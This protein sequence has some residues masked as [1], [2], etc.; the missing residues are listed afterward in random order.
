M[1][2]GEEAPEREGDQPKRRQ[3]GAHVIA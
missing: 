1:G 3:M 2:K